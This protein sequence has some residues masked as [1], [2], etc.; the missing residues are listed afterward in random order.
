MLTY[1]T[2][3]NICLVLFLC[4]VIGTLV[5]LNRRHRNRLNMQGKSVMYFR[6]SSTEVSRLMITSGSTALVLMGLVWTGYDALALLFVLAGLP[7]FYRIQRNLEER[8]IE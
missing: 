5:F 6:L 1:D 7:L 3:N 4:V 8:E 2:L